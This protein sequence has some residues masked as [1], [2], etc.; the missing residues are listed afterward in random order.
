MVDRGAAGGGRLTCVPAL[1]SSWEC[2]AVGREDRPAVPGRR[3]TP[4]DGAGRGGRWRGGVSTVEPGGRLLTRQHNTNSGYLGPRRPQRRRGG[5]GR[6]R[7][8]NATLE[9]DSFTLLLPASLLRRRRCGGA[10]PGRQGRGGGRG[11]K[12]GE[13]KV[14]QGKARKG[15]AGQ[16]RAGAGAAA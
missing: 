5:V 11:G 14:R 9:D 3:P 12:G 2:A 10:A 7:R 15:R 13:G 4:R 8:G 16:G 1:T 6:P